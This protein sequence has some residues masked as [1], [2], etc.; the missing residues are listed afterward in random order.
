MKVDVIS[1][2]FNFGCCGWNGRAS[3]VT[4]GSGLVTAYAYDALGRRVS[5][6][7]LEGTI[8]HVYD[9]VQCIADLDGTGDVVASAAVA[10]SDSQTIE[11]VFTEPPAPGKYTL[12]VSCR[13]GARESL[14]PAVANVKNVIVLGSGR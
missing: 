12:V 1:I 2:T 3:A 8:C 10:R 14:K 5:T 4:N 6:T 7:T 13:N 11:I 9:G